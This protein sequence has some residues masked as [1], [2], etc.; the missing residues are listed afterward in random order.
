MAALPVRPRRAA[1]TA[2]DT[3]ALYIIDQIRTRIILGEMPAGKRIPLYGLAEEF[4]ISRVPLREAMRQLAAEGLVTQ[5][6]RRGTVVRPLTMRDL[7][8][9]FHLLEYLEAIAAA[10]ATAPTRPEMVDA[11]RYWFDR[12]DELQDRYVSSEMLEAHRNFHFAYFNALGDGVLLQ[13]LH[14][15]WHTC[16]RYVMHCAPDARRLQRAQ[17]QHRK[18]ISLVA[19]GDGDGA[20][21]LLGLHIREAL[22]YARDYL[23]REL[24]TRPAAGTRPAPN[25]KRAK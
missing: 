18:L 10:R 15:L 8:D 25:A 4:G 11:M 2:P 14:I 21:D 22:D 6:P 20:A 23:G 13:V 17:S 24:S 12:M 16:Q 19:K 9:C 3:V 7:E 1:P 5:E